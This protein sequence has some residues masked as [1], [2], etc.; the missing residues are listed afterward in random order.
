MRRFLA[1]AGLL[2]ATAATAARAEESRRGPF[3]AREGWLPA[4]P[5]LSLPA[6]SPDLLAPG[7]SRLALALDWGND[8]G[9]RQSVAGETPRERSFLVDGEHRSLALEWRR[10]LSAR[11]ELDARLPLQ[12]R[13]GGELDGLIDWFHGFTRRLGLP[14]NGR[15][16]FARDQL[17]LLGRSPA[18]VP[19]E[20]TGTGGTGL[21]RL[22]LGSRLALVE[23]RAGRAP[24]SLAARLTLPTGTGPFALPGLEAGA[25]L[26]AGHRLGRSWDLY[27]GLG[28]SAHGRNE[29][30]GLRYEPLRV[31]GFAALE[32]RPARRLSLLAQLDGAG[33]LLKDVADYPQLHSYLRLVARLDLDQDTRLD[34]GFAEN[35]K[36]QQATTDF[37]LLV[38]V[39]RRF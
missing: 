8:F 7:R 27:A 12:W 25:Q 15:P 13:G 24:L 34:L 29:W 18:G 11:V 38:G 9:W 14:E 37:A 28:A 35:V 22:E 23:P 21:G 20:W 33:P 6:A 31:H 3:E 39:A 1:L 19:L 17:R 5:R 16:R 26:L 36:N 2:A 10:G 32:W 30:Q 4:Q